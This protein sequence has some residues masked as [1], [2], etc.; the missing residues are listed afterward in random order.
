MSVT[1][2]KE[3]T[4]YRDHAGAVVKLLIPNAFWVEDITFKT[5]CNVLTHFSAYLKAFQ[6][7]N[8]SDQ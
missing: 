4:Y 7:K 1:L 8:V 3:I 5:I 2:L 6:M